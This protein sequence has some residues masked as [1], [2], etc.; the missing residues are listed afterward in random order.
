MKYLK[1]LLVLTLLVFALR[2]EASDTLFQQKYVLAA[3]EKVADWQLRSWA[4][5]GSKHKWWDWTNAAGY[6]GIY[7]LSTI[8]SND[9]YVK[10]LLDK[11]EILDW[12]TGPRRFHADDYCIGQTYSLLYAKYKDEKMIA[13]FK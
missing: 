2:S 7:A 12:Q 1:S 8:S 9:A 3:M 4:D 6:T 5:S 13:K 10:S 11:G